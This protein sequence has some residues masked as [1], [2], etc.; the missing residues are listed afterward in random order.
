MRSGRHKEAISGPRL[1]DAEMWIAIL[2]I[3]GLISKANFRHSLKHHSTY[4]AQGNGVGHQVAYDV[5]YR[6]SL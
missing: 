6:M 5:M 2:A 1:T 3:R 4:G